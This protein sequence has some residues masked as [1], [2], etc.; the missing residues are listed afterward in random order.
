MNKKLFR[1]KLAQILTIWTK[2][3]DYHEWT[4]CNSKGQRFPFQY[5]CG[6]WYAPVPHV[7]QGTREVM[8]TFNTHNLNY[9]N[10]IDFQSDYNERTVKR[11]LK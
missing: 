5:I 8:K 11:S 7:H 2:A 10:N 6:E 9:K 3:T 1:E 4:C